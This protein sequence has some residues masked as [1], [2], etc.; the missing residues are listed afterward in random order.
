MQIVALIVFG[1]QRRI[2][3]GG[4][5]HRAEQRPGGRGSVTARGWVVGTP[6][7]QWPLPQPREEGA[8]FRRQIKPCPSAVCAGSCM[9]THLTRLIDQP[10]Q[11]AEESLRLDGHYRECSRDRAQ[12]VAADVTRVLTCGEGAREAASEVIS[13]AVHE[14]RCAN[15]GFE[16]PWRPRVYVMSWSWHSTGRTTKRDGCSGMRCAQT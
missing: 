3:D 2:H 4:E 9:L 15:Y 6:R 8:C 1:W 16:Q 14:N 12:R 10:L 13:N 11:R 7:C 5:R